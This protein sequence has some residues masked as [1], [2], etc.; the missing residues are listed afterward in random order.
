LDG[1]L[2]TLCVG[3]TEKLSGLCEGRDGGDI[4]GGAGSTFRFREIENGE[5]FWR[6][7]AAAKSLRE[8]IKG[9]VMGLGG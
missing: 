3:W 6:D 9:F 8:E 2:L 4:A 1:R 5:H 7:P